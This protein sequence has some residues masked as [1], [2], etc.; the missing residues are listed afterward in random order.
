MVINREVLL[1]AGEDE[2]K[3]CLLEDGLEWLFYSAE[4]VVRRVEYNDWLPTEV[5]F[6]VVCFDD[7]ECVF[8]TRKPL[9]ARALKIVDW[10]TEG[11]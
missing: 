8:F 3:R 4:N 5:H 9:W 2:G 7:S 6:K 1:R 11:F 10:A